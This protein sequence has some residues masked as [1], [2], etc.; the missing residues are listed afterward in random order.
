MS[1]EK[2][3]TLVNEPGRIGTLSED[4]E[5]ALKEMWAQVLMY[6]GA[7]PK[8]LKSVPSS[9]SLTT[10]EKTK[11]KK[12]S[13]RSYFGLGREL[14]PPPTP[15]EQELKALEIAL[16]GVTGEQ[17]NGSFFSMVKADH[18][19]NLLLRFLR[20]RKW[21]VTAALTMVGTTL[22]WR[23]HN[24]VDDILHSGEMGAVETKDD[25]FLLQLRS[26]KSYIWGHDL[27]G[28][29]IVH[30][31]PHNHDPKSQKQASVEKYTLFLIETSRLC[32]KDPVDTATVLFDL[33]KFSLSN[34][35]NGAVK[36][37]IQC[38]EGHFPESLGVLLIHQA[39]WVFSSLWNII[40]GWLDPN[41]VS[42]IN[43]T[44]TTE[45]LAKFISMDYIEADLGGNDTYTF[46]YIEPVAGENDLMKDQTTIT[47]LT[48]E[49]DAISKKFVD[50]TI[51]WIKSDSKDMDK[52]IQD[53]KNDLASQLRDNYWLL[54][55]HVRARS[56]FDRSGSLNAFK[57]LHE[58]A[59][60]I[61]PTTNAS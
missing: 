8:D 31:K 27:R 24:D 45:D 50:E 46:E 56:V 15:A 33:S 42:K 14:P 1:D 48:A 58:E 41:V 19:D 4:H 38:F 28:R 21:D 53:Q 7:M 40:K 18:P 30:V 60:E 13:K 20:A 5:K 51:R 44:Q 43:F 25:E 22:A 35:D 6:T 23:L 52:E 39:P 2:S 57:K 9:L 16:D 34:M 11:E 10:S 61:T 12:R 49:R 47:Q 54:D 55:P 17:L 3:F 37:I 26:K 32:L 36:F 59:W 29:P